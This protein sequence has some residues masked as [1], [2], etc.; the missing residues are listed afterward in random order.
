MD[1]ANVPIED[2]QHMVADAVQP[3]DDPAVDLHPAEPGDCAVDD[4]LRRIHDLRLE[5]LDHPHP[6]AACL[7]GVNSDLMEMELYVRNALRRAIVA[8]DRTIDDVEQHSKSFDLLIRLAKQISVVSQLE[9]RSAKRESGAL[10]T[11]AK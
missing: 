11:K 10:P 7:G 5:A 2:T 9:L 6:L 4:R 1:D 3:L 8:G